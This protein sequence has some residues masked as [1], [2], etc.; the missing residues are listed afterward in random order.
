MQDELT[1]EM[2]KEFTVSKEVD[3]CLKVYTILNIH[4]RAELD[5]QKLAK[6]YN[7]SIE[8]CMKYRYRYLNLCSDEEVK[9]RLKYSDIDVWFDFTSDTLDYWD[10]FWQRND[11]LGAGKYDPDSKSG[12]M[13]L[14]HRLLW[15][16]ELPNGEKMNL[17]YSARDYLTWNGIKFSSDSITSTFRYYNMKTIIEEVAEDMD[18]YKSFMESTLRKLYTIGGE[19]ILPSSGSSIN[20]A[21]GFHPRI[22]DRWDLTL[23]C[24]RRFYINEE[25]PLSKVLNDPVNKHFFSLFVDFKGFVDF[26]FFQDC[27]S[28][29]YSKVFLKYDSPL[30]ESYPLPKT[31]HDYLDYINKELDFVAKRNNRIQNYLKQIEAESDV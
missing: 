26:F 11:G 27:V 18:D 10:G 13:Q 16:K 9:K 3:T 2:H 14:F 24:I 5:L 25:S 29:D 1:D 20:T 8:T 23:E 22:K 31:K 15:N 12:A 28:E 7:V 4:D 19:M 21:R 17:Q 30:F 6:I